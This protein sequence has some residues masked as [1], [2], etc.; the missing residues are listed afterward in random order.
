MKLVGNW[1]D[2]HITEGRWIFPNGTF[3]QGSFVNDKPNGDGR[4]YFQNG[5]TLD[6][7]YQ[8]E[9]IPNEDPDEKKINMKLNWQSRVGISE[10]A[11][12]V[13]AH[14]FK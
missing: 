7:V 13:N 2:N 12:L 3:Y 6:G 4:W 11:S 14:E 8:Q 5:N 9:I 10:S 1:Q